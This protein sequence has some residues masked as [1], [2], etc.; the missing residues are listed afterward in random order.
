[1][2]YNQKSIS[3]HKLIGDISFLDNLTPD[4]NWLP[5]NLKTYENWKF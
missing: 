4:W 5:K 2:F 1:M 3:G